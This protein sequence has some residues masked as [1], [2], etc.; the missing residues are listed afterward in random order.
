MNLAQHL[1]VFGVRLY[2][3]TLSPAKNVIFGP[4]S[5]CR[6]TPSCSQYALEAVKTHGAATGTVMGLKRICRCHPWGDSGYDPVPTI[7]VS[8]GNGCR[9]AEQGAA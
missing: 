3:W 1:L 9:T 6:F 8:D 7:T 4:F 5:Q 2:R